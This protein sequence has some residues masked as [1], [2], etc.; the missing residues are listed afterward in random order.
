[1][2]IGMGILWGG[3]VG[4]PV[5]GFLTNSLW[6]GERRTT[7]VMAVSVLA[8]IGLAFITGLR[9]TSPVLN[10][11]ALVLAYTAYAF[12]TV[13]GWGISH[14]RYILRVLATSITTLPI[15]FGYFLATI[16]FLGLLFMFSDFTGE[17]HHAE[18]LAPGIGCEIRRNDGG[19]SDGVQHISVHRDLT[20]FIR[21][22][23]FHQ[24]VDENYDFNSTGTELC[25]SAYDTWRAG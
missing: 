8:L 13:D 9:F 12:L 3:L 2:D 22:E 1:M 23:L 25:R 6:Q 20:P 21:W 19:P 16:G 24:S 5:A 11:S 7:I 17:P 18:T 4:A 10:L 15:L 14:K